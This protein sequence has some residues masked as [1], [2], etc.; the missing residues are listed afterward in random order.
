MSFNVAEDFLL[1]R[2][3]A[4]IWCTPDQDRQAN[5]KLARIT[6]DNGV[7]S[8]F[9]YHWRSI[10]MPVP[11]VRFH[12]YQIG[13]VHPSILGLTDKRGGWMSVPAVMQQEN[14]FIQIYNGR[15]RVVP[16]CLCWYLITE[17]NNLL[18]AVRKSEQ[19]TDLT[20]ID[21]EGEA[22]FMRLYT[23]AYFNRA[24]TPAGEGIR[25][26][27]RRVSTTRQLAD[28][29]NEVAAW[30][31]MGV[32]LGFVNGAA[33]SN[34]DA[35][36]AA[37]GDYIDIVQDT[38][39]KYVLRYNVRTLREFNSSMDELRKYLLTH[40]VATDTI[41][42]VD[43]IDVYVTAGPSANRWSGT[44]LHKNDSRTMRQLTHRDWSVAVAR[45]SGAANSNKHLKDK[46][47]SLHVFVRRAGYERQLELENSRIFELYKLPLDKRIDAMLGTNAHVSV[48][49]AE[50]LEQS[51]YAEVMRAE[52]GKITKQMVQQAYGYNALS[53][54]LGDTP[55]R[56]SLINGQNLIAIPEGLRGCATVYEYDE[57]G[58]LL[59]YDSNTVDNTHGARHADTKIAE[60]VFG[61]AD[62]DV[63]VQT[64]LTGIVDSRY[65]Y[66][67]YQADSVNG[68]RTGAW[69]DVTGTPSY[70]I[71]NGVFKWVRVTGKV[72]RVVSNKKFL[73]YST[74]VAATGGVLE[75]DLVRLTALGVE[76]FDIP[77]GQLD[78]FLNKHSL[79]ENLDYT[80]FG[81]RV[82]I[83]NKE[84]LKR[85]ATGFEDVVIRFMSLAAKDMKREV[86][87]EAG[88]VYNGQLSVNNRYD[89]RQDKVQRITVA[90]KLQLKEDL[91]F[92]E[93]GTVV[94]IDDALN[95]KPYQIKDIVVP[96]N[97]YLIS[98][99]G[100]EDATYEM[101][102]ASAAIDKEVSDY[103]TL[104]LPQGPVA[105]INAIAN[106]Y[107][108]SSPF[109]SRIID[110]LSTGVLWNDRFVEHFGDDY[111]RQIAA[112]YEPLL[113]TDPASG[114]LPVDLR[115]CV[116]HP[117]IEKEYISLTMYQWRVLERIRNLY[118]P[119]VDLSSHVAVQQF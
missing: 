14:V 49:R 113:K 3:Y 58:L 108:L 90:G 75:F 77:M 67:F 8:T 2:A 88:F 115:Y 100:V 61:L 117:H 110:D 12:V 25:V 87:L 56:T 89:L 118:L 95:G 57:N 38:S 27:S 65:N 1:R 48:W 81:S 64:G 16:R 112:P 102:E 41:D 79:I 93:S 59:T 107:P 103:L 92:A 80:L 82:T 18:L 97:Q 63:D 94:G 33:V 30:P 70:H 50:A 51:A 24:G 31:N 26:I 21:L 71:E 42:Y 60:V 66:R 47:L 78:L 44:Y 98:D 99:V 86:P 111:V 72:Y 22:L 5:F 69:E 6:P 28:I 20:D 84:Y 17:D 10:A 45:V 83:L 85:D 116:V 76:R 91:R 35:I 101:R 4:N 39:I 23:N 73:G 74:K 96:M 43:D 114:N 32:V 36:S 7:W 9:T 104:K 37:V 105:P 54:I 34:V 68:I 119:N 109:L 52:Q 62:T 11:R 46:E 15:G 40:D 29:Q 55:K 106:R 53:V 13:Q 19:R